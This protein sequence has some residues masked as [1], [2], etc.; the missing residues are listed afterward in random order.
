MPT[1]LQIRELTSEE[2]A[3]IQQWTRSRTQAARLV[4]RAQIIWRASQGHTVAQ[5]ANE[6]PVGAKLVRRWIARFNG[7]GLNG[8]ADQP[9]SGRPPSYTRDQVGVV[10]ATALPPPQQLGQPFGSWTFERLTTYLNEVCGIPIQHSR[11][12]EL[13]HAEGLR[14]REQETWFGARVDPAFAE[15]RGRLSASIS[16][17]QKGVL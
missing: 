13:L 17:L 3:Q 14:W 5:I 9:R 10:V 8:L 11:V 6:M 12:H 7:E 1:H 16:N 4:K 2:Q 15:K